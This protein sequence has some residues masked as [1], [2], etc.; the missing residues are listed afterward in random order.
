MVN[1]AGGSLADALRAAYLDPFERD[2]GVKV[3]MYDTA[4][5]T[6]AQLQQFAASDS[7]PYDLGVT[8]Y[9]E[10][11]AKGVNDGL[12]LELPAGFWD[13]KEADLIPGSFDQYGV[14]AY[15][16]ARYMITNNEAFPDGLDSWA[17]FFD[18][19]KNPGSRA[20]QDQARG[21]IVFALLADGLTPEE[22][23]PMTWE[24]V[25]QAFEKLDQIKPAVRTL[26]TTSDQPIQ[27]TISGDFAAA[28]ATTAR[29]TL[30]LKD[31]APITISWSAGGDLLTYS[32]Y[33]LKNAQNSNAAQALLYYMQDKDRQ[34]A[35][36]TA[37]GYSS[38][39]SGVS[40]LVPSPQREEIESIAEQYMASAEDQ[41]WWSD[42]SV[43]LQARWDAWKAAGGF[44]S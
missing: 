42:N 15:V 8:F 40:E 27:G 18:I 35:L 23:Y 44:A 9:P 5:R 14:W 33:I 13:E 6:Y 37:F 16:V 7:A 19:E 26:L 38:S 2:C 10:E 31:D 28:P 29:A 22:I 39:M 1:T 43:E 25:D 4:Q 17:D 41:A 12:F 3:E 24:K 11:F 30:A 32:F 20:I 34:A 21:S 36:A